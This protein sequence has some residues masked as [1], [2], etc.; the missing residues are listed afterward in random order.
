MTVKIINTAT[1]FLHK[2]AKNK[3]KYMDRAIKSAGWWLRGEIK[4]GIRSGAPGGKPYKPFS[5]VTTSRRL[6]AIRG[7]SGQKPRRLRADHKPMG[8]LHAA[9]RYKFYPDSHRAIVGWISKSA[10]RLGTIQEK[11]KR[12]R[13]TPKMRRF[14]LAAGFNMSRNKRY[15]EIPKR[16]TIE[17]EY[18]ENQKHIPRYVEDKIW[19]YMERDAR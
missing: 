13:V 6:D 18:K 8:R 17:P 3:P 9:V 5:E 1:P 15:I 16:P 10:E 11:G 7:R 19:G 14:Y 12:V 4:E 2:V